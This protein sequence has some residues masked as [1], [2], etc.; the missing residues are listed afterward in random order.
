MDSLLDNERYRATIQTE[1]ELLGGLILEAASL[2]R[3]SLYEVAKIITDKDFIDPAH[4]KLYSAMLSC[5]VP[6]S[7]LA[8]ARELD[9]I[10]RLDKG[11]IWYMIRLV[12]NCICTPFDLTY[13]AKLVKEYSDQRQ[14]IKTPRVKGAQ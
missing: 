2:T 10:G 7:Y 11:D 14:G 12:A 3:E 1:R 6:T 8:I 4:G 5:N 13:Y 9:N